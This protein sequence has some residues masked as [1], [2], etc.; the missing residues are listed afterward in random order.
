MCLLYGGL[1]IASHAIYSLNGHR[2]DA[3]LIS[4][5]SGCVLEYQLA[6]ESDLRRDPM[7]CDL[8]EAAFKA[9]PGRQVR[10]EHETHARLRYTL[11]DGRIREAETKLTSGNK[12][13][14]AMAAGAVVPIVYASGNPADFRIA[15][16]GSRIAELVMVIGAGL[17]VLFLAFFGAGQ[18][19]FRPPKGTWRDSVSVTTEQTAT[20]RST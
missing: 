20:E 12:L 1:D 11:A 19:G 16:S 5:R 4:Q 7:P 10:V 18:Q 14:A 13:P 17:L 9:N 8:A 2:A 3:T 15:L 6:N